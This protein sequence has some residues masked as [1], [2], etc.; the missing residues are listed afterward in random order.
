MAVSVSTSGYP[1]SYAS[2]VFRH[3]FDAIP[4]GSLRHGFVP[5]AAFVVLT[6]T[7]FPF[8]FPYP[9]FE[10]IASLVMSGSAASAAAIISEWTVDERL[11]VVF[12]GGFDFIVDFAFWNGTAL[13]CI[14]AGRVFGGA[15]AARIGSILAWACWL[16]FLLNVP[17]NLIFVLMTMGPLNDPWP[18]VAAASAVVRMGLI[19]V[20]LLFP[21]VALVVR[22]RQSRRR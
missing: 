22:L 9:N 20:G 2:T 21:A 3:P 13:A 5:F 15:R 11:R 10:L 17:E 19:I 6:W 18:A 16:G 4:V 8:V 7:V 12:W 14:W 1:I